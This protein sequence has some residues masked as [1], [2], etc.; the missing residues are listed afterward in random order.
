MEVVVIPPV[1][2]VTVT[3]V[4]VPP[5]PPVVVVVIMP[6]KFKIGNRQYQKVS[7]IQKMPYVCQKILT[8]AT[9]ITRLPVPVPVEVTN[10]EN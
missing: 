1:P 6:P 2:P 7:V 8:K 4:V 5:V 10:P 3:P 9:Q